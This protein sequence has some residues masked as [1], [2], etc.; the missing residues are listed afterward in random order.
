MHTDPIKRARTLLTQLDDVFT[1]EGGTDRFFVIRD[2]ILDHGDRYP[3]VRPMLV[4]AG[5]GDFDWDDEPP[6][7]FCPCDEG[8]KY[9]IPHP[10]ART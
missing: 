4:A 1:T 6:A 3:E 5:F 9:R 2:E 7:E 8:R 10:P